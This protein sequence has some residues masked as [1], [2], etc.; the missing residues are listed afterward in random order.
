[1][2]PDKSLVG[3]SIGEGRERAIIVVWKG[4]GANPLRWLHGKSLEMSG[5]RVPVQDMGAGMASQIA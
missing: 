2:H 5:L 3:S 1:M 4:E